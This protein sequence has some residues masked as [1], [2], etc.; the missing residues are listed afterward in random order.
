MSVATQRIPDAAS[1]RRLE[2]IRREAERAGRV[3]AVGVRPAGAPFPVASPE[4]G[5]YGLPLLKP[6]TWT[7]EIP[8]YFFVGG[9]AGASALIA[10]LASAAAGASGARAAAEDET[11]RPAGR[12][13]ASDARW[14]AFGGSLLSAALLIRDLG[15]PGRFLAMLRVFKT[16]SPMSMGAWTLAVFGS[17]TAAA[18]FAEMARDELGDAWPVRLATFTA[19]GAAAAT[20]MVLSTYTGVL[21]GAT[22]VPVWNENIAILPIHFA[23][24]GVAS[25]ASLLELRGHDDQ[26]LHWLGTLAAVAETL[27]GAAIEVRTDR[28]LEPLKR[29]RPGWLT[30]A[31]GF[32]S[33]PIPLALRLMAKR[34]PGLRR[35]AAACAIAGS[36]LTRFGWVAAG[37]AST[38]DP[39]PPLQLNEPGA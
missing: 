22:A 33:G 27:A 21:I 1:E 6:P 23:A 11:P 34:R 3:A 38:R 10:P 7:W 32:L 20:G 12:G 19:D 8:L 18:K 31:G 29:G 35:A 17:A 14:I 2:D 30:R 37:A 13:T 16:S 25:A 28:A 4:K 9:A 36:L 15:R 26:G 5:Y 24:S 39:A